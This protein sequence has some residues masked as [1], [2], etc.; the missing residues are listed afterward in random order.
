MLGALATKLADEECTGQPRKK[1][2]KALETVASVVAKINN[3]PKTA[4]GVTYACMG[5]NPGNFTKVSFG[6][7]ALQFEDNAMMPPGWAITVG[8]IIIYGRGV[9]PNTLTRT[10][11]TLVSMSGLTRRKANS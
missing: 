10:G 4:I 11:A 1:N 9:G 8:N 5:L 7:N 3:I 6:N 2:N